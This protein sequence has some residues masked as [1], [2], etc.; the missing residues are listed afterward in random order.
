MTIRCGGLERVFADRI[1]GKVVAMLAV[2][3]V[4]GVVFAIVA[5]LYNQSAKSEIQARIL[6]QQA[7]AEH[8]Q[9]LDHLL[10]RGGV[11]GHFHEEL[12]RPEF[13]DFQRLQQQLREAEQSL[14]ALR[15]AGADPGPAFRR[16]IAPRLECW[17]GGCR[18]AFNQGL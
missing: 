2:V 11:I 18:R 13:G 8:F 15:G 7:F 12:A 5:G 16:G 9:Q 17:C 14:G 6:E 10:E 3:C 4:L 1:A